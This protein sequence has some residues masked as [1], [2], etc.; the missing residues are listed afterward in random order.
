MPSVT[1]LRAPR[2]TRT[3]TLKERQD[4]NLLRLP[5][6]PSGQSSIYVRETGLEPVRPRGG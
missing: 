5:I 6:P 1:W 2:G 4:L 3:P